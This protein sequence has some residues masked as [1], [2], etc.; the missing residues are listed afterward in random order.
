M[1]VGLYH[2]LLHAFEMVLLA[3]NIMFA[4]LILFGLKNNK[5]IGF[6]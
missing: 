3:I 6:S 5:I 2:F 1:L 4:I